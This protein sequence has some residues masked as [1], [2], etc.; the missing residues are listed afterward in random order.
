[1]NQPVRM[2]TLADLVKA[3]EDA[4]KEAVAEVKGPDTTQVQV[5]QPAVPVPKV[6]D[7]YK[8]VEQ[9][10]SALATAVQV[11]TTQNNT[12][13]TLSQTVQ[14][15]TGNVATLTS[16]ANAATTAANGATTALGTLQQ[17]VTQH[18]TD[19]AN[20]LRK[21][22]AD[23]TAFPLGVPAAAAMDKAVRKEELAGGIQRP[24]RVFMNVGSAPARRPRL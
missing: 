21:D 19:I 18:T 7:L 24:Y 6:A 11:I 17:T 3:K 10:K 20:R 22:Q 2:P 5:G 4:K 12:I 9:M 1:M 14:G 23:A 8:E 16:A 13:S 15:L